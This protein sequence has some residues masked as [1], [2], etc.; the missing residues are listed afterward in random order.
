VVAESFRG[1]I[2]YFGL[3][4]SVPQE[5]SLPPVAELCRGSVV[6]AGSRPFLNY[7][8]LSPGRLKWQLHATELATQ[9]QPRVRV[10]RFD[11]TPGLE[12]GDELSYAW[13]WGSPRLFSTSPGAEEDSSFRCMTC[14]R[15]FSTEIRFLHPGVGRKAEFEREPALHV[16]MKQLQGEGVFPAEGAEELEYVSYKWVLGRGNSGDRFVVRWKCC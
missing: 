2:H 4:D 1:F 11:V 9:S 5:L 6:D 12:V 13:E 7:R 15:Q 8:L 16:S 3:S 14:V 10:V